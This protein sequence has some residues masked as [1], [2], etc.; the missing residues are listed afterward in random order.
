[1]TTVDALTPAFSLPRSDALSGAGTAR[2]E[3]F[4]SVLKRA[5][6]LSGE[7]QDPRAAAEEFV[8]A[9]LIQPILAQLRAQNSAAAPFQP[10]EAEKAFGP[11]LDGEMALQ[12]ARAQGF[13]VVDA[14]ARNLLERSGAQGAAED[15]AHG[16]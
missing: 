10:G 1:M 3:R 12:I 15:P 8:A 9:T 6:N 4:D 5:Q 16:N 13:G 7:A 2:T 11:L 14:V